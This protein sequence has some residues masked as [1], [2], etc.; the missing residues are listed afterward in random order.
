MTSF[1]KFVHAK[2]KITETVGFPKTMNKNYIIH[3]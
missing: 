1:K 2:E 3:K